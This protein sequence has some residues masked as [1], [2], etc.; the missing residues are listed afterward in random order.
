MGRLNPFTSRT[1]LLLGTFL[2]SVSLIELQTVNADMRSMVYQA[3]VSR[4]GLKSNCTLFSSLF[5]PSGIYESPVGADVA[6]GPTAIFNQCE[7]FN[8]LIGSQGS[9]WYPR[10]FFSGPNRTSFYLHVRTVS[11]GG[12][13]T[14]IE[15]IVTMGYDPVNNQILSWSHYYDPQFVAPNLYGT[16][17]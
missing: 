4:S 9:G 5:S 11:V 7:T 16:C 8:S 3:A 12:C 17:T 15:G 6:V 10:E 13:Q 2:V 1:S 14:S